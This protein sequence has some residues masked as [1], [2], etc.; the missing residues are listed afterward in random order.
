MSDIKQEVQQFYDQVGW[1]PVGED[2]EMGAIYQNARYE[3][4]RPVAQEYIHRCHLR[5]ARHLKPHGR[6]LLDAGSGPVQ[7]PEYLV[8]ARDYQYRVCAD[9]SLTA[10]KEAQKRIGEKG[11]YVV[12]DVASLPFKAEAFDGIVS[13]HTIH[14]LPEDEHL[15][16]YQELYRV[17]LPHS[18]AAVV[19]GWPD[20]RLM[21][22]SEPFI[23]L[24]QR[25]RH[26]YNR[27]NT[28][29]KEAV[30]AKEA[31][32]PITP[33]TDDVASES[34]SSDSNRKGTFTS[35]HNVSWIKNVVGGQMRVEILVWRTVS[36]RFLRALIHPR[37]GG[38]TWLR[39][40]YWLEERFPHFFG[41]NG[42]YPLIVISKP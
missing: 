38:R 20:S 10:L 37:L 4:L 21:R 2:A 3:D 24:G 19:N 11:L 31:D 26:R 33:S 40:L 28:H 23:K 42:K 17:L 34:A 15:Q 14:H 29:E 32:S 9:I 27:G 35:R 12:T 16:A 7:Y 13:L 5:V 1:Q 36:V 18:K 6:F 25:L 30:V 8:Y 41:E 22:L 39:L